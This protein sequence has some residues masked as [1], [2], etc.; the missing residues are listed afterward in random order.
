MAPFYGLP[1]HMTPFYGLP[2][3]MCMHFITFLCTT[4]LLLVGA[5]PVAT[6]RITLLGGGSDVWMTQLLLH[7]QRVEYIQF[8][9]YP[10]FESMRARSASTASAD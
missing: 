9:S 5:P 8:E 3:H 1:T 10:T 7:I 6:G 2:T 4:E